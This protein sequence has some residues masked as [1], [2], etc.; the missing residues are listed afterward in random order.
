MQHFDGELEKMIRAGTID[1][2]TG[3]GYASNQGNLALELADL[4]AQPSAAAAP[5][6]RAK[7]AGGPNSRSSGKNY[8]KIHPPQTS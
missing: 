1:L 3:L 2:E 5:A 7:P 8:K 6:P 4:V